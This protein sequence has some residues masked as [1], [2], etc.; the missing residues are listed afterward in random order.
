[1]PEIMHCPHCHKE[2]TPWTAP[3]D[4]GWGEILVC[5]NNECPFYV[6]SPDNILNK[7]EDQRTLG[8][9]YAVDPANNYQSF[10]LLAVCAP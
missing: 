1:M 2:L 5:F 7:G 10:S 8:C 6:T 3:P 4:S 9:R